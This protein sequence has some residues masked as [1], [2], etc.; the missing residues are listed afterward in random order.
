ML[1]V[2]KKNGKI[3]LCFDLKDLN[4]VVFYENYFM[5]IIEDIV[6][7]LYGVKV[8]LVFDIKNGFWYVKLDAESLYFIIFFIFFG[9]Y[10]WCRK[11]FGMIFVLEV[12]R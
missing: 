8:F 9:C 10:R 6:I 11:L 7:R 3:R 5:F 1:V 12:F 2:F 4:K